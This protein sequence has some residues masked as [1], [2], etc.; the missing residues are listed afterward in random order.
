MKIHA[1]NLNLITSKYKSK[2]YKQNFMKTKRIA[3]ISSIILLLCLLSTPVLLLHAQ[4]SASNKYVTKNVPAKNFDRISLVGSPT[5]EYTQTAGEA[6]IQITGSDNLVDLIEC[7]VKGNTLKISFKNNT[8]I[9]WGKHGRLKI[10]ASSPSLKSASLQ[11]SG[12]IILKDINSDNFDITLIGSGDIVANSIACTG[13]FSAT[14]QGSGDIDIKNN[15]RANDVTLKLHG[16][17]DLDVNNI[18]AQKATA[19]L[20]GSGDLKIKGNNNINS[21]TAQVLGSGDLD[22]YNIT[23]NEVTGGLQGSGDLKLTGT[24]RSAILTLTNSGDLDAKNLQAE[25]VVAKVTGSGSMSCAAS[26]ILRTKIQGSGDIRY[27]G[28][29]KVELTGKDHLH[30]L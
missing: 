15:I 25:E 7:E 3:I 9:N 18:S 14:L 29:P 12:D 20:Q 26:Q 1:T 6:K 23:A 13:N 10:L 28:N 22:F 11:G 8:N 2:L 21:V 17:G 5:V 24:T 30:R 16:S 27:K 4:I 19:N